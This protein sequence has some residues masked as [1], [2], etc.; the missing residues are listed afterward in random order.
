[1]HAPLHVPRLPVSLGSPTISEGP[2]VSNPNTQKEAAVK[3]YHI[4]FLKGYMSDLKLLLHL[5][6]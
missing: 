2:Q 3:T 4:H 1:M 6:A 5:N